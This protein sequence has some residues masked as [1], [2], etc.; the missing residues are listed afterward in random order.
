MV[1]KGSRPLCD[2]SP[3]GFLH[4][5]GARTRCSMRLYAR[6]PAALH[7]RIEDTDC[8][9]ANN[10]GRRWKSSARVG[11]P[12]GGLAGAGCGMRVVVPSHGRRHWTSKGGI[13]TVIFR[14]AQRELSAAGRRRISRRSGYEHEGT[15]RFKIQIA[16]RDHTI[17]I[18]GGNVT[19]ELTD[20]ANWNR[21]HSSCVRMASTIQLSQCGGR[22]GDGDPPT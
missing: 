19:G 3:T 21:F 5:G 7:L 20:G 6:H 2:P 10:A 8:P 15:V 22:Y 17:P 4:I 18:G 12:G 14:A 1:N 9:R 16:E 13:R 11:P